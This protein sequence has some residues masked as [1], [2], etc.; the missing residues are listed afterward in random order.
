VVSDFVVQNVV[1]GVRLYSTYFA[2]SFLCFSID[3]IA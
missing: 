3:Y 2:V 1:D